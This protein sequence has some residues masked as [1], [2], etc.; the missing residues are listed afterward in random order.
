MLSRIKIS[1]IAFP[2][3]DFQITLLSQLHCVKSVG[4]PGFELKS[5]QMRENT[6]QNN[7]FFMHSIIWAQINGQ[8]NNFGKQKSIWTVRLFK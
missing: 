3:S 7:C 5:V 2:N 4:I 1:I 8:K 6:D